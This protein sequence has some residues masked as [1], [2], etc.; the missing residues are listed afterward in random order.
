[1]Q[2]DETERIR[3]QLETL[4]ERFISLVQSG[5]NIDDS[6]KRMIDDDDRHALKSCVSEIEALLENVPIDPKQKELGL[7]VFRS[8]MRIL[9]RDRP[10]EENPT[11]IEKHP[12]F[13]N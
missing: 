10:L 2:S 11:E 9:L 8:V 3:V 12:L 4:K 5:V 7:A 13:R 1:M 6:G